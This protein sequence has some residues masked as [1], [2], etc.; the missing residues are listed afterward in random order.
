MFLLNRHWLRTQIPHAGGVAAYVG[1][2]RVTL[3]VCTVVFLLRSFQRVF[4]KKMVGLEAEVLRP[5]LV[6]L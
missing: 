1:L 6:V 3:G 5:S 2:D 4:R